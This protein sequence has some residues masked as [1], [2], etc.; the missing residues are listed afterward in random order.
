[1]KR[2][3]GAALLASLAAAAPAAA[4]TDPVNGNQTASGDVPA[5]LEATMPTG[6]VSLGQLDLGSAGTQSNVQSI[7]VSSNKTW[8]ATISADRTNMTSHDGE[9]YGST[10]LA[11][12]FQWQRTTQGATPFAAIAT[13][14]TPGNLLSGAGVTGATPATI[15]IKFLQV[16]SYADTV[17]SESESPYR[18]AINYQV[19]QGL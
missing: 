9:N 12:P 17:L 16:T 4:A 6:N 5:A 3:I 15:G 2:I 1:M 8:G 13:A 19:A 18:I 11:S 14:P 10:S 7:T